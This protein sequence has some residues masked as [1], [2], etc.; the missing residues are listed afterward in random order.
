MFDASC[1]VFFTNMTI[2]I[3]LNG[4]YILT[5]T[6]DTTAGPWRRTLENR[7]DHQQIEIFK[8]SEIPTRRIIYFSQFNVYQ[9]DPKRILPIMSMNQYTA[10]HQISPK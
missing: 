2:H 8:T 5:G 3:I 10:D 1:N 4:Q 7:H 9:R 6:R